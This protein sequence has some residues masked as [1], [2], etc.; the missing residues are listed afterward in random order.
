MGQKCSRSSS[1]S[2][3]TTTLPSMYE[4]IK[5]LSGNVKKLSQ[6]INTMSDTIKYNEYVT[7]EVVNGFKL[8]SADGK[9]LNDTLYEV[10]KEYK[11]DFEP[12]IASRGRHFCLQ[13]VD[14]LRYRRHLM[15]P[16]RLFR[17]ES[18]GM[19]KQRGP[20]CVSNHLKIISEVSGDEYRKLLS[21]RIVYD[22]NIWYENFLGGLLHDFPNGQ[23]AHQMSDNIRHYQ[24]GKRHRSGGLP[25]TIT[26]DKS[27]NV[28]E[29][30]F[31]NDLPHRE[32]DLPAYISSSRVEYRIRGVLHRDFGPARITL[33]DGKKVVREWY[34]H[35]QPLGKIK[36]TN[37]SDE[38][39]TSLIKIMQSESKGD[40]QQKQQ[41]QDVKPHEKTDDDDVM[42][43]A[44]PSTTS[45]VTLTASTNQMSALDDTLKPKRVTND[46]KQKV[47]IENILAYGT[48]KPDS[49]DKIDKKERRRQQKKLKREQMKAQQLKNRIQ[50]LHN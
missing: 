41:R 47:D 25:A 40:Q 45:S 3:S 24:H 8:V 48:M 12:Q 36:T 4:E 37:L 44:P 35:G 34:I 49:N 39:E 7:H 38:K 23:P 20:C 19:T 13:A 11:D 27:G 32:G 5:S 16:Y 14:C 21:G 6:M 17:V 18:H 10:G 9:G 26:K 2:S 29:M 43:H 15:G 42:T 22:S 46:K 30:Y 1:S 28:I 31:E 50:P 33:R